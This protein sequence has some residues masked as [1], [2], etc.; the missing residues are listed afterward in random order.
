MNEFDKIN[1]QQP[2]IFRTDEQGLSQWFMF[3][4]QNRILS[5]Q[6][7]QAVIQD[8]IEPIIH[9]MFIEG[10]DPFLSQETPDELETVNPTKPK[11]PK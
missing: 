1:I 5:Y 6:F 3:S 10:K 7:G 9:C 11:S 4:R 2:A 8:K